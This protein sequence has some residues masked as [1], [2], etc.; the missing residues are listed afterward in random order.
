[1]PS[2]R[3]VLVLGSPLDYV[4]REYFDNFKKDYTVD[5]SHVS[6]SLS[7]TKALVI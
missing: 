6:L 4:E 3:K 2:K 7:K 1:M 5:V